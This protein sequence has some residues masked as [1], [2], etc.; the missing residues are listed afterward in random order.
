MDPANASELRD[1]LS[2]NNARMERQEEQIFATGRAV[3]ALVAQVSELTA[4]LQQMKTEAAASPTVPD[5]L[6]I[7]PISEHADRHVEPRLPPPASYSGEPHLCQSFLAK[8]S[9]FF[10]LQPLA[11]PTEQSKVA[12][13]ITL[14]SGRAG[15]WGTVV[16]EH[17]HPCCSSFQAFSDELKKVFDRAVAGREAARVL[18]DLKQGSRSVTDYSIEFRTLAA[19]CKWNE[20][21][22]WD[23]FLH[24]LADRIQKEIFALDLPTDLDG[25]IELAIRVDARLQRRDQRVQQSLVPE[26]TAC[27]PVFPSAT[28]SPAFD[29]EPMQVGRTRLSRE[30]KDRRRTL[31]LCLYCGAA[32]HIAAQCPVKDR[33][34]Q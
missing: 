13:V 9:L 17:K 19:E 12:L 24:G 18:A 14:L 4:Q 2:S 8:C 15:L 20:E 11:F 33:A 23:M 26:S 27:F 10:A 31:G 25:L 3:Q 21:A 16:W 28:V 5:S 30:E 32:G 34:H 6:P 7:P 22:Q 1:I 29:P